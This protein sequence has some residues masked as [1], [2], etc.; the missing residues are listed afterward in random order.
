MKVNE[1]MNK[2]G[3]HLRREFEDMRDLIEQAAI[4]YG[5]KNAGEGPQIPLG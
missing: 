5:E 2:E 1:T 3:L 4:L